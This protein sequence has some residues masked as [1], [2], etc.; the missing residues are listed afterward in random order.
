MSL[1][2]LIGG[3]GAALLDPWFLLLAPAAWLAF[4][5][6][7]RRPRAALPV[8]SA[9]LFGGL[10]RTLRSRLTWLPAALLA[11][12]ATVLSVALARPVTRDVVP[13]RAEGVD[14]VLAVDISSSMDAKDIEDDGQTRRVEA[15][16]DKALAFAKSRKN[17]RVGLMTFARYA[18]LRCP[19]TLDM[20]ALAAFIRSVDTVQR[21]SDEDL[22][23]IGGV[24]AK[25]SAFLADV[26]TPSKI[27]VL[28]SDGQETAHPNFPDVAIEPSAAA[29]LAA[30]EDVK[31]HTIGFGRF[32][33]DQFGRRVR[34][35][36]PEL[37]TIAETTGGQ[38]FRARTADD[39][40][41][42]YAEIDKME[43][44]ELDDPRYRTTDWF[45]GPLLLGLGIALLA[46][47]AEFAWIR[48]LP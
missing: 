11:L 45:S 33:V 36:F 8:A 35:E 38:F 37:E 4:G 17:D 26:D 16:R 14:I 24:V 15:V 39:L 31:V 10:P 29:E 21:G 41:A 25:A 48:G 20:D 44:R 42:V 18:D 3:D 1:D 13:L 27:V 30:D 40:E 6:R 19:P 47:L 22:T 34:L 46:L 23:G 12:A 28:L 43:K 32:G 5:W 2:W 9:G 7:M